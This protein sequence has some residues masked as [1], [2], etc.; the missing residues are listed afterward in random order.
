[1]VRLF[2]TDDKQV[3]VCS[4]PFKDF[5]QLRTEILANQEELQS[6]NTVMFPYFPPTYRRSSFGLSLDEKLIVQRV[7]SLD[8]WIRSI[9]KYYPVL[10]NRSQLFINHFLNLD[11]LVGN[12]KYEQGIQ[13]QLAAGN[14]FRD[15]DEEVSRVSSSLQGGDSGSDVQGKG[16]YAVVSAPEDVAS[17]SHMSEDEAEWTV[18]EGQKKD[19]DAPKG[20]CIIS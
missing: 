20:C 3:T 17:S 7:R 8:S 14:V 2:K 13:D 1:M 12:E 4:R 5:R 15:E 19:M 6:T 16:K 11:C 9:A 10:S 18:I